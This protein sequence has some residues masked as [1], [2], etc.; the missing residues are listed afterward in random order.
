MDDNFVTALEYGLPP[1]GGWGFGIDRFT[2]LLTNTINIKVGPHKQGEQQRQQQGQRQRRG[3]AGQPPQLLGV[4]LVWL[5]LPSRVLCS[6]A[7]R[8]C[9][10]AAL[11]AVLLPVCVLLCPAG[12]AAVPS[13]E[14]GRDQPSSSSSQVSRRRSSRL[15]PEGQHKLSSSDCPN[16]HCVWRGQAAAAGAGAARLTV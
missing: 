14:A 8:G 3:A 1:T 16:T 13:H 10:P 6:V 5:V 11:H 12:G 9:L 15:D 7:A 4:A 2:M